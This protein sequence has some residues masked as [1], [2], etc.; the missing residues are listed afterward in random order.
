MSCNMVG[1]TAAREPHAPFLIHVVFVYSDVV[2]GYATSCGA[3][4]VVGARRRAHA[5][6]PALK[7]FLRKIKEKGNHFLL[8]VGY[9]NFWGR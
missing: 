9:I 2:K 8:V 1:R 6:F 4:K 7:Q 5:L 3:C